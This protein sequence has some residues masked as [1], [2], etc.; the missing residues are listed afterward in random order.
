MA[1][2]QMLLGMVY[3]QKQ[4]VQKAIE[5]FETYL[6]DLPDAPN[7]AQVKEAIARLRKGAKKQ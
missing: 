4:N 1:G 6:R 7:A 2:A 5:A 3:S